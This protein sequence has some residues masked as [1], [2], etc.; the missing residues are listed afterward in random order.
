M[1]EMNVHMWVSNRNF[2]NDES[3]QKNKSFKLEWVGI[4]NRGQ[5]LLR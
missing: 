3:W 1:L 2:Q 4:L 5:M